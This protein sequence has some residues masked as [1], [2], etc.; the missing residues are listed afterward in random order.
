MRG[1]QGGNRRGV[2]LCVQQ[3]QNNRDQFSTES[4]RSVSLWKGIQRPTRICVGG[5]RNQNSGGGVR[6]GVRREKTISRYRIV[7]SSDGGIKPMIA[8]QGHM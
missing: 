4:V 1:L 5:D 8:H 7:F 2:D 6:I 3:P